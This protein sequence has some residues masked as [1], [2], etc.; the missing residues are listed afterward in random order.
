MRVPV[1]ALVVVVS[2]VAASA[3][4]NAQGQLSLDEVLARLAANTAEYLRSVPSF[5]CDE[6]LLSQEQKNGAVKHEIRTQSV[7]RV[8]HSASAGPAGLAESRQMTEADGKPVSPD[9]PV[10][11]PMRFSGGFTR[12]LPMIFAADRRACFS[13]RHDPSAGTLYFSGRPSSEPACAGSTGVSVG[14]VRLDPATLQIT[15]FERTLPADVAQKRHVATFAAVD[16]KAV[17]LNGETLF[18]PSTITATFQEGSSKSFL[19]L[20]RYSGYHRFAATSTIVPAA[21]AASPQ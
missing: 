19:F 11:L 3:R 12:A 17:D 7:F 16:Y 5:S 15:H 14:F 21:E 13:F 1:A 20:A 9:H 4:S 6:D 8:A 18:L 2:C 10:K